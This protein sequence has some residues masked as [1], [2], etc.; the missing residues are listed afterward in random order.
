MPF[1]ARMRPSSA[2]VSGALSAGGLTVG[3]TAF[4]EHSIGITGVG[5]GGFLG[6]GDVSLNHSHGVTCSESGGV[7]TVSVGNAQASGGSSS[8]NIADT[9]FYRAGLVSAAGDA[10]SG[11]AASYAY[12]SAS[13]RYSVTLSYTDGAGNAYTASPA[14]VSGTEAYSDGLQNAAV[15]LTEGGWS[16]GRNV[17]TAMRGSAAA[18]TLT[19]RLP[20]FS[21]TG[22]T[23][24]TGHK[25]TV[26]FTTPSVSLPLVSAE[27][28]ATGQYNAGYAAGYADGEDG[29][30]VS[31]SGGTYWSD[32]Q[33]AVTAAASNGRQALTYVSLPASG[34]F[35]IS[36]RPNTY[37]GTVY[38]TFTLGGRSYSGSQS[39]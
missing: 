1:S 16:N 7:V 9:A 13:H 30:T 34:S 23:V 14:A 25:T 36:C 26:H 20:S 31:A 6:T 3:G 28:D 2:S 37:S 39:F 38:V 18:D 4:S 32:G 22:G 5:S 8:F 17:I 15:T 27:V 35:S 10:L 33:T 21:Y 19:V 29:V 24:F 12:N 11:C